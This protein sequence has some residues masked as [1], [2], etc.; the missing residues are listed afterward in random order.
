MQNEGSPAKTLEAMGLED[1]V[2]WHPVAVSSDITMQDIS[3][4]DCDFIKTFGQLKPRTSDD[5]TESFS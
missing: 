3:E 4:P 1:H 2:R 5:G